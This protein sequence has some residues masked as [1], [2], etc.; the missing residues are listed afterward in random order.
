MDSTINTVSLDAIQGTQTTKSSALFTKVGVTET[1]TSSN[2]NIQML[3]IATTGSSVA[4]HADTVTQHIN[5]KI[6][7]LMFDLEK[8]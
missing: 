8:N 4:Q 7:C 6:W 1:T 3:I 5:R 2:R